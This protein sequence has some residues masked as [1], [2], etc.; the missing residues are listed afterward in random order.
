MISKR[1]YEPQTGADSVPIPDAGGDKDR[2]WREYWA[3]CEQAARE[4]TVEQAIERC[5]G[6][7]G[8]FDGELKFDGTFEAMVGIFDEHLASPEYRGLSLDESGFFTRYIIGDLRQHWTLM[9]TAFATGNRDAYRRAAA[10]FCKAAAIFS[11]GI[12]EASSAG[13]AK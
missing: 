3:K 12:V 13:G 11:F 6:Q 7:A 4:E 1:T 2:R 8:D 9:S 5:R 10:E